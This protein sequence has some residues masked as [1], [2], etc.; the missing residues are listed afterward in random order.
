MFPFFP[1]VAFGALTHN[2]ASDGVEDVRGTFRHTSILYGTKKSVNPVRASV[3]VNCWWRILKSLLFRAVR[4]D[5]RLV[6]RLSIQNNVFNLTT[7]IGNVGRA[8]ALARP[9]DPSLDPN[10][11]GERHK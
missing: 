7:D 5:Q 11:A 1:R 4:D 6:L 10:F 9:S 3:E 2:K 8:S